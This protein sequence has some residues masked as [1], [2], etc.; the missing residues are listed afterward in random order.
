MAAYSFNW[1]AIKKWGKNKAVSRFK[2]V[3]PDLDFASLYDK[4]FPPQKKKAE[5]AE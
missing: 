5:K 3:Y 1:K 4:R 2:K